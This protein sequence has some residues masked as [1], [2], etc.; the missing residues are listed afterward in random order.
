MHDHGD[1]RLARLDAA[2]CT[3]YEK[4]FPIQ[5]ETR[6]KLNSGHWG[7]GPLLA[8]PPLLLL[9]VPEPLVVPELP[10]EP[11]L[12]SAWSE[13]AAVPVSP[14]DFVVFAP[15]PTTVAEPF[16]SLGLV[17]VPEDLPVPGLTSDVVPVRVLASEPVLDSIVP[18]LARMSPGPGVDGLGVT[19]RLRSGTVAVPPTPPPGS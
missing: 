14:V 12:I 8:V 13:P 11:D 10:A 15:E 16:R 6:H 17:P 9:P 2:R 18:V 3:G 5:Q 7:P 4:D 19:P 1:H